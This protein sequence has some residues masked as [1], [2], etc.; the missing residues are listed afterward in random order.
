VI[1]DVIAG[2]F[3]VSQAFG[4]MLDEAKEALASILHEFGFW[5]LR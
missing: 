2:A 4:G 5:A 1:L 3:H